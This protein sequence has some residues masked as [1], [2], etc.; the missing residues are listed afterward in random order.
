MCKIWLVILIML[1]EDKPRSYLNDPDVRLMLEVQQ[2]NSRAFET[3]M[4][5]YYPRLLNF[6]FR[7]VGRRETAEDLTQEVFTAVYN[8]AS[9]YRPKSKF[10]TWIYT[11]ARNISLNELRRH[12]KGTVSLDET[13][14]CEDG[15]RERQIEDTS[16]RKPDEEILHEEMAALVRSAIHA[17]PESQRMAVILC[18]YDGFS[19]EEI[20]QTMGISVQAVKSLLSR[21]KKNLRNKLI[22][23]ETFA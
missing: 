7:F 13:V 4:H 12:K 23:A 9:R 22:P 8:T 15:E 5:K 3:L 1:F 10:Q 17:L 11:I 21:A 20:A 18:R 14:S 6:I 16:T 19:Y 2:G